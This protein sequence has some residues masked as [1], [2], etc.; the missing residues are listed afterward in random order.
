MNYKR[1][2]LEYASES[3]IFVW[4]FL[5]LHVLIIVSKIPYILIITY[6]TNNTYFYTAILFWIAWVISIV[7]YCDLKK[8]CKKHK[9][10][11]IE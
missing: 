8:A 6:S 1:I 3:L 11:V 4:V 5:L 10:D 2:L 9:V 7:Y